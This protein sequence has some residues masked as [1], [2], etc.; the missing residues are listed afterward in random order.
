MK[1]GKPRKRIKQ[2]P[3]TT[4]QSQLMTSSSSKVKMSK[5]IGRGQIG[6]DKKI[7]EES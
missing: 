3:I 5:A 6:E 7:K 2:N 1:V 4:G